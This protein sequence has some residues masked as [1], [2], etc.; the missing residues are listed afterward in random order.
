MRRATVLARDGKVIMIIATNMHLIPYLHDQG[1]NQD[2]LL[3]L[4]P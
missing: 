1:F 4:C 3:L 2:I